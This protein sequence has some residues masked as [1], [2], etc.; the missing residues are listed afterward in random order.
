MGLASLVLMMMLASP[1]PPAS[2]RI[3]A[4][5]SFATQG[6]VHIEAVIF[7]DTL[8]RRLRVSVDGPAYYRAFE[9]DMEGDNARVIYRLDI[10]QIPEGH[11]EVML[12]VD[13]GKGERP[14]VARAA[15]CR[16]DCAKDLP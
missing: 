5:P 10:D 9:E 8:N 4:T 7:R 15:L 13:R 2:A 6:G 3:S 16:G 11:Y 1:T 14:L 12:I